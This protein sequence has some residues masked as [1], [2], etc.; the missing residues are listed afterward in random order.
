LVVADITGYVGLDEYAL[1]DDWEM[2]EEGKK[3]TMLLNT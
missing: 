3:G 1:V 2:E